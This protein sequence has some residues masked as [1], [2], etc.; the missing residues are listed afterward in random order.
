MKNYKAFLFDYDY[1][2]AF[3]EPAILMCFRHV[4]EKFGFKDIDDMTIKNTIGIPLK[5]ALKQ[6]TGV[7]DADG[8]SAMEKTFQAKADEVMTS[9]T[10]LYPDVMPLFEKLIARGVKI[11]IVSNKFGFRIRDMLARY[12]ILK[13]VSLIIGIEDVTAHKPLPDGLLRAA[14]R[15]G[16]SKDDVIYIGDSIIDSQT[17]KN[18]GID[19]AAVTTGT[20][21]ASGFENEPHIMIVSALS[22]LQGLYS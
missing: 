8:L 12:D 7:T 16:V 10:V 5:P 17:A 14:E 19:F 22:Q 13:Y 3:S 11:G 6:M 1:T 4:F 20:T 21:P 15:L 2:L 9:H 18:A